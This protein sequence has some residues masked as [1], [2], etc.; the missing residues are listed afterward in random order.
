[1]RE[2]LATH[3]KGVREKKTMRGKERTFH[4]LSPSITRTLTFQRCITLSPVTRSTRNRKYKGERRRTTNL[5]YL[6]LQHGEE[7]TKNY[8]KNY[9]KTPLPGLW[10]TPGYL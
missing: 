3:I 7:T 9:S 8:P 1:M 5:N 4:N 10:K 6:T 2:K